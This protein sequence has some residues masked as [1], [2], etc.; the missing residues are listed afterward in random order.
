M[1]RIETFAHS[2]YDDAGDNLD[3]LVEQLPRIG[4]SHVQREVFE[5]TIL[6]SYIPAGRFDKAQDLL[7]TRLKWPTS[8]KG[9]NQGWSV[10]GGSQGWGT[11]S[12]FD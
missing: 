10:I 2:A 9:A 3:G 6:E 12:G 5:D 4:D 11:L 7:T 1:R 8:V